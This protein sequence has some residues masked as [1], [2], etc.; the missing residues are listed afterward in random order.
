MAL[1]SCLTLDPFVF[2][3]EQVDEY[4]WDDDPCDPQLAGELAEER[5]ARGGPPAGCHPSLI[6]P[7]WREE[8]FIKVGDRK[9]HWVYVRAEGSDE[10]IFYSHGRRNHLG[11][12]WDRVELLW[13]LGYNVM[14]YD[15]PTYGRSTG[16][17]ITEAKIYNNAEAVLKTLPDFE[18]VNPAKIYYYG[19]SLGSAP[20]FEMVL[21]AQDGTVPAP[22]A[23]IIESGICSFETLVQ[24][25]AF[26][27]FPGS[28]FAEGEYDN[29]AK[30]GQVDADLPI[31]IMHGAD[32]TFILPV[33]ATQMRDNAKGNPEFH[34]IEGAKH[35]DIPIVAE[36]EYEGWIA[37]IIAD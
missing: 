30:I 36:D 21:R 24:D 5:A 8:G 37:D 35:A 15:Y 22:G 23:L 20:A 17:E 29:C 16:D 12:Y 4:G 27:D 7:E 26:V 28:F 31:L 1:A 10:T 9:V 2:T 13:S 34:M 18:G 6:G 3:A 32:E 25:G 11:R 19:Y 14:I 33:H